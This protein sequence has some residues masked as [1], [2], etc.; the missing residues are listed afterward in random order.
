MG[1]VFKYK[2]IETKLLDDKANYIQVTLRC[3]STPCNKINPINDLTCIVANVDKKLQN[4]FII[5]RE[6]EANVDIN[7]VKEL[8][9]KKVKEKAII[10]SQEIL[11]M[12]LVKKEVN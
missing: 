1:I 11:S 8:D 7:F 4:Q 9:V 6:L 5:G 3:T 2:V 10:R 12:G